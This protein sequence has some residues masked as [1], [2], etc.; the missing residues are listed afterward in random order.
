MF[1][2]PIILAI[3][4]LLLALSAP[5]HA[6][7]F[8]FCTE[9]SPEG[10][11]PARYTSGTTF[12]ASSKAIY[13]RLVEREPGSTKIVPGLAE[14]W[15]VSEDGLQ[16]VFHLRRDVEFQTTRYYRPTRPLN[17]DDVLFS[18]QRQM[19]RDHP[20]HQYEPN[21]TWPYFRG[22]RLAELIER[23]D[24][25]DDY[26]VQFT[27]TRPDA[28][29][30]ANLALD[31]ASILS[32]EYATKLEIEE[33]PAAI[34][35]LPIGTGPFQ[36]VEY[37]NGTV[38]RLAAHDAYWQGRQPIDD[39]VFAIETDPTVRLQ[40]VIANACHGA[41]YPSPIDLRA[42]KNRDDVQILAQPSLNIGY[43][44]FNTQVGPFDDPEVRRAINM[45]I[46]KN[47]IIKDVFN[48]DGY[49]ANGPL[50]PTVWAHNR[51]IPAN[52]FDPA[53]AHAILD[54][55]GI[56]GAELELWALPVQR[57]YNPNPH[58]MA[59]IIRENLA[60]V[61]VDT[62]IVSYEWGDYLKRSKDIERKGLVLF[63]WTGDNGDPDNFF[64]RLLT[65]DTVRGSNRAHWCHEEFDALIR[66]AQT[67]TNSEKRLALY[68]KA[69]E[70]FA[71]EMPW[72]PI[73]HAKDYVVLN[74]GVTGFTMDPLGGHWF[75]NVNL[76]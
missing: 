57:L 14:R 73:A 12:D 70:I 4:S 19:D 60:N 13:D 11:D 45:A 3:V 17:A 69:Q 47:R 59:Q 58:L 36:L 6:K 37:L 35:Y 10:F 64:G 9:G 74:S 65:C 26:T 18:F 16:Y 23:I 42:H 21:V 56:T 61:G 67:E 20:W 44:A 41:T 75:K 46:D 40:K 39:L 43:L 68:H 38:A 55:K 62:K 2:L 7:T 63:G 31:F 24:R 5:A 28:T 50:P 48:E 30:L 32:F 51:D 76:E 52:V 34:N 25:I 66:E 33:Q 1:R 27:L 72:V 53:K 15:E 29:L 49:V 71:Q 54:E 8:T 22:L